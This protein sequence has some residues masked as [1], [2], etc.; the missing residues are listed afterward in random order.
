MILIDELVGMIAKKNL[1]KAAVARKLGMTPKTF[2]IKLHKG[3]L[4]SD[5]MS[6]L[7]ELLDIKEPARIFFAQLVT[8]E[9]T[10]EDENE[11]KTICN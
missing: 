5:E 6:K 10:K 2:Y 9:V 3:V 4:G 7:V 11:P 8:S 1:S